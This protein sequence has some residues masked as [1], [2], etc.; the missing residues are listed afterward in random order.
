MKFRFA[1]LF[2]FERFLTPV[3][4]R[5]IFILYLVGGAIGMIVSIVQSAS[6]YGEFWVD[7]QSLTMQ[8]IFS[9]VLYLIGILIVRLIL[10]AIVVV[11]AIY[12]NLHAMKDTLSDSPMSGTEYAKSEVH[13]G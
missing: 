12:N 13:H 1:D 3:L 6:M 8:I 11:F 9:I 10:E 5:V 7:Q 2:S 4:I